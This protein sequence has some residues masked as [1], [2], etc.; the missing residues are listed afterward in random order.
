M[1]SR[2][3]L[4]LPSFGVPL[5][6]LVALTG[7]AGL[8]WPSTYGRETTSWATQAIGGDVV[9]LFV[10][11]P[12]LLLAALGLHRGS[13]PAR[14]VWLG[15]LGYLLYNFLIYCFAVHFNALFLVYCTVLGLSFFG[16]VG[17]ALPLDPSA[18]AAAY[19]SR[20]PVRTTAIVFLLMAS[21]TTVQWVREIVDAIVSGQVPRSVVE[22]GLPVNPIWVLDLCFLLPALAVTGVLLLRRRPL[23]F[24]LAPTLLVVLALISAELVAI[25]TAMLRAGLSHGYGAIGVV[26]AL[27]TGFTALLIRFLRAGA[28]RGANGVDL[29]SL[30]DLSTP[31]CVHVVA[32]LRI[33]EHIA[34]GRARIDDL[35]RAAGAHAESLWRVMRHLVSRGVFEEP[36][37]GRFA[38][39]EPARG[40]LEPGLHL[41]LDLDSFGGRMAGAWSSLL[42]AVRTGASAYHTVFGRPFWEDLSAHPEIA[43]KFDAL[44]GPAGHGTPHPEV[45][46]GG[47]WE[48]VRTVVDVGGGA[49]WLLAEVLRARPHVRGVLV[50]RPATV[51]RAAE[52]FGAAG[53]SDRVTVAGQSFFDPL[54]AGADLYLLKN[55]LADWPDSQALALLRRCAEAA[56]PSG[57][58]VL[59]GGVHPDAGE[60]P[61]PALLMMVLV[62]GK[63]R[64]LSEFRELARGAGL[65]VAASGQQAS[66]RFVVECR[67]SS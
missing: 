15:T 51:A 49:G 17:G 25:G 32:T 22:T 37:P 8:F 54:P 23:A 21:M 29:W 66:G 14:L 3:G 18:V 42:T 40:L 67:P 63:E 50:D 11:A 46:V 30:S 52:V 2:S 58:V 56:R 48:S 43:D 60:G 64:S 7:W 55:V 12:L 39:N 59:L 4:T 10:V 1:R 20:A 47:D 34:D 35:A 36:E 5:V 41:A 62:G 44:M 45:L 27:G 33:A 65:E 31:W 28:A 61:A 16:F 57:R 24:V 53:V 26:A 38:L 19:G 6:V 9:N 13:L